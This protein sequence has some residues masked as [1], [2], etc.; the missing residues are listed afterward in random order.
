MGVVAGKLGDDWNLGF[1]AETERQ[2]EAHLTDH[3]ERLPAQD[4]KS[5]EI[6]DQ[7][8]TDE[9]GHAD[10]AMRLGARELPV[11]VKLIM[12]LA[13]RAMTRTAYWV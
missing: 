1:L 4:G 8:R 2:V 9:A 13:S 11:P 6:L 3:L 10:T 7:M 5:R 12:K